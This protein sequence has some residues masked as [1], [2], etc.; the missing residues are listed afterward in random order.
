MLKNAILAV[1]YE[2]SI[3]ALVAFYTFCSNVIRSLAS[4][5]AE[6]LAFGPAELSATF[7]G[8]ELCRG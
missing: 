3:I 7:G 4:L 1:L 2:F 5:T 8:R 6:L